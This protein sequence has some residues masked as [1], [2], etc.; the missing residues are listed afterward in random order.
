M[1]IPRTTV[2]EPS[3]EPVTLAEVKTYLR[4]I[5]HSTHD[6][7]L[8][9]MIKSARMHVEAITNRTFVQ[10]T[11]AAYFSEWPEE[12]FFVLPGPPLQSVSS[13]K[14]TAAD[15]TVTTF[16]STNYTVLT[17]IEPGRVILGY[18]K[19]W[20]T[21]TLHHD[22]Y[23][24]EITYVAGY[25]PDDSSPQD[26]RANVPENVKHAIKMHVDM[27]YSQPPPDYAR[28][29]EKTIEILLSSEKVW[30]F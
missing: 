16:A 4:G 26:Y 2:V 23:P 14:Y 28:V 1:I 7:L 10:R 25:E 30:W 27:L 21:A 18:E 12:D 22:D 20:P 5:S 17:A 8:E 29:V 24:I 13:V 15:G 9:S 3:V 11:L 19:V 6:D